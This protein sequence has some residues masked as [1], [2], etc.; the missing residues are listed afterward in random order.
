MSYQVLARKWR[1][2][3]FA[4]LVGQEHVVRA[5]TNALD[6]GRMHHAYLFTG[7]RGVGKTTIARIF[8]KS[9][10]CER[11]ESA[12][13]CG[14]CAVCTAV[15][16][17]RFVDLLEIDAASNTGVD[18]VRE[19]IENAQ[20]APSRGRFKVYLVDEVHM[21]SKPAFN[22]LLKTLEEPPPHVKF[23]LA[24][25]DPQ[26]LPVTVLSRCLKF[27]LK[28]L[29]PEQIS[30]QMRHILGAEAIEYEEEAIGELAHGA[31]GSLRDGLSLL[32]Q[33][34]AYG[35]G[36][37]RAADVRAMLGSVERGQVLGVLE[38]L[39]SGDGSALMAEA[40]RIASFS[41]DFGGVLD[42][43]ATVLHRIQLVQL[44]PGYRAEDGDDGLASL[45]ERIA[46][47]DVQLYYQIAT[48]GRRELPMAPDARIGFEMVLLR[49]HAFRPAEA[50]QGAAS[51]PRAAAAPVPSAPP[52]RPAPSAAA[53][54]ARPQPAAP[55]PAPAPVAPPPAE[56]PRPLTVDANGLPDW[57]ELVERA[58]LRGP[59][60]QLAQ[61]CSLREIDGESMVL[62]LTPSHMHLAVE[63]LTSQMEEKVSQ[64]IGRRVRFRFVADRGNLGTPAERRAQVLSDAQANAEASMEADPLVQTL[65]RDFDARVIPQSIKPVEP[66][67]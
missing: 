62:A 33:A 30:G 20:Y 60:G 21:L 63:P 29:L 52:P 34:I 42:D 55:A 57:H 18:D 56:P 46:P 37:L 17:G 35:G 40:D 61:N 16:A 44:V 2:R 67:T 15:D 6:S 1:P 66:G 65:K 3:K 19:V 12:D 31:D 13:P 48:N 28:R 27:N 8:A 38:A 49:M 4:E 10:N 14:E 58:N 45:A 25:T 5:L 59:I 22:A 23:L 51:T 9:L 7:T 43:L 47:E 53:P 50:G 11:G 54:P 36:S 41:P 26:K 64:A 24:T 32:D 39:A